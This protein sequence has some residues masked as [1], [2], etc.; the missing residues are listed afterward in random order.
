MFFDL[1]GEN[2]ELLCAIFLTKVG[3]VLKRDRRL[4]Q[5]TNGVI[6]N[7]HKTGS[8]SKGAHNFVWTAVTH[9]DF[10]TVYGSAVL[11]IN[12]VTNVK[13]TSVVSG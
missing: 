6:T 9:P 1:Y 2:A 7:A 11:T 3:A 8:G 5:Q 4:P 12:D 13:V 10:S